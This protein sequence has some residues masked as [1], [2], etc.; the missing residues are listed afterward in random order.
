MLN[1]CFVLFFIDPYQK[2]PNL[3]LIT[4]R[5][6]NSPPHVPKAQAWLETLSF[7]ENVKLGLIDLHPDIYATFPR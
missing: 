4:E 1:V 6:V 5:D 3:P 2:W 7:K